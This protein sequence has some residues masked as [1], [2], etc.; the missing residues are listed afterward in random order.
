[1][2]GVLESAG[3]A[4]NAGSDKRSDDGLHAYGQHIRNLG[5]PYQQQDKAVR[6]HHSGEHQFLNVELWSSLITRDAGNYR[7]NKLIAG[8]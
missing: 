2:A 8:Q 3:S 7:Y 5:I 4:F 6:Y 1:M